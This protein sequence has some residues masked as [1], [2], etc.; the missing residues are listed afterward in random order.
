MTTINV[1]SSSSSSSSCCCSVCFPLTPAS[2]FPQCSANITTKMADAMEEYEKEAG[3][4]PI[5]H[6]EVWSLDLAPGTSTSANTQRIKLV[7]VW[8]PVLFCRY[9]SETPMAPAIP[10]VGGGMQLTTLTVL[11][12][13]PPPSCCIATKRWADVRSN[14]KLGGA[15][16]CDTGQLVNNSIRI[17]HSSVLWNAALMFAPPLALQLSWRCWLL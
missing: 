8:V 4:V 13:A 2:W 5:L 12:L 17:A 6:S 16:G 10:L 15:F 9:F 11:T 1:M 14:V 7:C 3:C